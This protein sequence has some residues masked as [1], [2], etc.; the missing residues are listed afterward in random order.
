MR[1][2]TPNTNE[3]YPINSTVKIRSYSDLLLA[4]H[5][6]DR[7]ADARD[8]LLS[9]TT[10]TGG[11]S[12]THSQSTGNLFPSQKLK[13]SH[14]FTAQSATMESNEAEE[15]SGAKAEEEKRPSLQ[16]ER[17]QEPLV[18]LEE[19]ISQLIIL[20]ILPMQLS[21]I[22][23]KIKTVS[24]VVV[25]AI[26][27]HCLKDLSKTAQKVSLN[28]KEGMMKKG[29]WPPQKPVGTQLASQDEAPRD[30]NVS[31]SSLLEPQSTYSVEWTWEHSPGQ[32]WWWEQFGSCW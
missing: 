31:K 24:D 7:W 30:W 9:K 26:L 19:Q 23:G 4:A 21:C 16:L 8:P 28:A 25:L 15:D 10:T 29:G 13:G 1:A 6:L 14:S 3:C 11:S 17:M 18:E 2:W 22:R 20:S 32:D 12:I 5:T 27:W